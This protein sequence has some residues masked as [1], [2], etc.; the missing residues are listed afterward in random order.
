MFGPGLMQ[1]EGGV[2]TVAHEFTSAAGMV[3]VDVG[4]YYRL[5]STR[6]KPR[7]SQSFQEAG[8]RQQR[9]GFDE[10]SPAIF[11]HEKSR[12]HPGS[13][14]VGVDTSDSKGE[15]VVISVHE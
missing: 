1:I 11:H 6:R 10:R 8:H 2:G 3:E 13:G 5:D 14:I 12:R 7:S 15:V 9:P 4:D